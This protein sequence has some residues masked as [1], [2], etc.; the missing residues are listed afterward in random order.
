ML[1]LVPAFRGISLSWTAVIFILKDSKR[2]QLGCQES[3]FASPYSKK[4]SKNKCRDVTQ[5]PCTVT[6]RDS[7]PREWWFSFP[8]VRAKSFSH[9]Q[10]FS[11][12]WTVTRQAPLSDFLGKSTGVGCHAFL[13]RIFPTQGLNTHLLRLLHCRQILSLSPQG[14]PFLSPAAAAKSLQSCPA[15]CDPID[16]RTPSPVPGIL[17]ASVYCLHRHLPTFGQTRCIQHSKHT[18][19]HVQEAATDFY[20]DIIYS[21]VIVYA[22]IYCP[23]IFELALGKNTHIHGGMEIREE[24]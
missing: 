15:L 24:P 23:E 22:S 7:F 19:H 4:C 2:C 16:G 21:L 13:Q 11:T 3:R 14:S 9:V 6:E 18:T 8:C 20:L 17:Q 1:R 5:A 12:L 10:L